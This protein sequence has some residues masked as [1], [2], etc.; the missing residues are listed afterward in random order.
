MMNNNT[1]EV[2]NNTLD[3]ARLQ[4]IKE[5]QQ[6]NCKV[7]AECF[8][9]S[10]YILGKGL[11]GEFNAQCPKVNLVNLEQLASESYEN[12]MGTE[13]EEDKAIT[14]VNL[15]AYNLYNALKGSIPPEL[16]R[17]LIDYSDAQGDSCGITEEVA[18][19]RG[20]VDALKMINGMGGKN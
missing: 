19:K 6:E 15:K 3:L 1:N 13:L 4:E 18:Y 11:Q 5:I 10:Q 7:I 14:E 16:L 9:M 20:F 8:A 2:F 17:L 12:S